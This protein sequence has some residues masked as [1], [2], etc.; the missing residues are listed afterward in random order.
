MKD[1]A[2][3]TDL[4]LVKLALKDQEIFLH[5]MERYESK[6]LRYIRRFSGVN[7]ETAEDI[8]QEVFI[9]IYRNLNNFDQDLKFSS[10]V[11][12]ITHNEILN[13]LKKENKHQVLPIQTDDDEI[14]D[15]LNILESDVD[16]EKD[17]K[18][19]DLQEN[20]RNILSMLSP[21]FRE[22]LLLK[23]IEDKSYEEISDILQKPIG[24]VGT[25][26]NRAK[27]QFKQIVEKNNLIY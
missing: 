24:T 2:L 3:K 13:Q 22:I 11:Y 1:Y 18:K 14:V 23:F 7:K 9:K 15:L 27:I 25:L 20:V 19:K 17:M 10:W 5:L 4:E 26:I 6:L 12:R 8:L 16:I 21:D